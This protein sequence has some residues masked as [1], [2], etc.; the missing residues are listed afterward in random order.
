M[1]NLI[2]NK[3]GID[4]VVMDMQKAVPLGL[5]LDKVHGWA[6]REMD[7]DLMNFGNSVQCNLIGQ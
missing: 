3:S 7:A 5:Q 1:Q 4:R 2:R 6:V